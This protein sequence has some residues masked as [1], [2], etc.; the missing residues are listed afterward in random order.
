MIRNLFSDATW[1]GLGGFLLGVGAALS[2][3]AALKQSRRRNGNGK[4]E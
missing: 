1:A 2:G 4:D 3:W